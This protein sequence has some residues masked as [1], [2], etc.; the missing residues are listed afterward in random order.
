[1]VG[2]SIWER[3]WFKNSLSQLEGGWLDRGGS[4]YR[5]GSGSLPFHYLFCKLTHPYPVSLLPIG[6]SYSQA[7]PSHI[8]I[9]QPFSNLVIIYLL[10]YENGTDSVP[11][12]RHIKFRRRGTTQKNHTTYRTRQKFEI[13]SISFVSLAN[14]ISL[15]LHQWLIPNF[16]P[17]NFIRQK[18]RDD[19]CLCWFGHYST[20]WWKV[21]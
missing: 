18:S 12:R 10:A 9:P 1:M 8:C 20:V 14:L 3:V 6:L 11:K 21:N 2:V 16:S 13:K 19:L 7:K 5:A 4:V 17:E 15:F